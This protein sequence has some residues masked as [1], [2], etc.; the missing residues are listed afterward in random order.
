MQADLILRRVDM[1]SCIFWFAPAH[2]LLDFD[3]RHMFYSI[4]FNP[5]E[6]ILGP[7]N[8][9]ARIIILESPFKRCV[10]WPANDN[11]LLTTKTP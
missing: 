11:M 1:P 3:I 9:K 6:T 8:C 10:G 4:H 2:L 5:C 7:T